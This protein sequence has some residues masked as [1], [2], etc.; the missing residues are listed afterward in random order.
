MLKLKNMIHQDSIESIGIY[1]DEL[2][3]HTRLQETQSLNRNDQRKLYQLAKDARL[4]E[5]EDLVPPE[6]PNLTEVIHKGRNTL[7]L[8]GT[9]RTFEK[10]FC[11]PD[12]AN[13]EEIFGYNEGVTR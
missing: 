10:R 3:A 9:L 5:L 8:P 13:G 7:P 11:R 12:Q 1:L 4:M 6:V 2:E